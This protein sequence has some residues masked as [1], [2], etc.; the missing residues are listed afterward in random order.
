MGQSDILKAT[1]E[2]ELDLVV[3]SALIGHPFHASTVGFLSFTHIEIKL[4]FLLIASSKGVGFDKE[5]GR[6]LSIIVHNKA[7]SRF[8]RLNG[9]CSLALCLS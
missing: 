2:C 7:A 8:N 5:P 1:W 9:V 3:A 4:D 6:G